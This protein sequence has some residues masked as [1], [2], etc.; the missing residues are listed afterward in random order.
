MESSSMCEDSDRRTLVNI[1]G[2]LHEA[3]EPFALAKYFGD[4][5]TK[6][7][8]FDVDVDSIICFSCHRPSVLKTYNLPIQG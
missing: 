1:S 2:M 3:L 8:A 6:C 5:H 7:G 4:Y